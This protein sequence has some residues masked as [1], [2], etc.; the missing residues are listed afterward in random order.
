MSTGSRLVTF[1]SLCIDVNDLDTMGPWWAER[2]G[3]RLE[4]GDDPAA[5]AVIR[6]DQPGEEVWLCPVPETKSVKNRV[7]LDLRTH[8][9][10]LFVDSP[11]LSEPGQFPWTVHADPEGN[12][13]C[14][15]TY[16][17][18]EVTTGLKDVVVDADDAES[19]T[20]WWAEVMGGDWDEDE[21]EGWIDDVPGAPVDSIDFVTV[22]EAKSVKNRSHWDVCLEPG[23][24]VADLVDRGATI[25]ADRGE[26][27]V[28]AD[29]QGNEFCVF[30]A[31][32]N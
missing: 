15:F 11:Q 32:T 31:P 8:S 23:V 24:S 25:L 12:E 28:M 3:W 7:H 26:W 18:A 5:A 30:P 29:P 16:D 21:G 13:F 20:Q 9:G 4:R 27:T 22:P 19:I 17:D 14:V 10:D 1:K 2:L 6:G